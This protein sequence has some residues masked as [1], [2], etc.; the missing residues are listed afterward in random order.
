MFGYAGKIL[1]I[2]LTASSIREVPVEEER[3]RK[4]LS[5]LG[6]NAELLYRELKPGTDPLGPENILVFNVGVLVG[7]NIPT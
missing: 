1:D 3:A 6:F 7:T 5:G 4:Y 2:D